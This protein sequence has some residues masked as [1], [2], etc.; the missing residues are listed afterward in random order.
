M[1]IPTTGD[2]RP[3]PFTAV[4][5]GERHA[6]YAELTGKGPVHRV[7][8]PTGRQG[9]MVTSHAEARALLSDPRLVKGG[10]Q[11][12]VYASKLGEDTARAIH[13]S[14]LHSDPP[15][16][17]RLRKLITSVF[18]R[19]RVEM[20]APG[21]QQM[22]GDLLDA[23]GG[24]DVADLVPA[25]AVPLP[26]NVICELIGI[27]M[28]ARPDFRSWTP[29]IVSPDIHGFEE[30]QR[31]A[32]S[33]LAYTRGLIEDKRRKPRNDLLSDL[34]AARD[35]EHRLSED[36]L[37]SMVY[38]LVI[39]GHETAAHLIANGVRA[40][41]THPGQLAL[42]RE[43]P[44][45][46]EPAIEEM[47]RYDGPLQNTLPYWTAEPV[48]VGGVTIPAGELVIV[49]LTAANRD[50]AQFP[51]GDVL[52]I[53]RE[54]PAHTAFGHGLHYCVGAPLARTEAR[55]AL[56]ML[57]DRYPAL[58]LAVPPGTLT[59]TASLLINGLDALPVHLR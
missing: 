25:L 36:E 4:A 52:D 9:W 49:A 58:R 30:Y 8:L 51:G 16:H 26:I 7:T 31:A 10:W 15:D 54:A 59:R 11:T 50:P 39:A 22:T 35:G 38:L 24:Q 47:L 44:E 53:T 57:L 17:T 21:I 28:E 5:D 46:L 48:E 20:L 40:L 37:T 34:I 27:P 32:L 12:G 23:L 3:N 13:T 43:R 41:L 1:P 45:L 14:M 19:R 55:I 33:M 2:T 56:G 29:L 6:I 18:T 42:V